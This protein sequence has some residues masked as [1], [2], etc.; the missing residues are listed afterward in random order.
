MMYSV[1]KT[2][3]FHGNSNF[4]V[5]LFILLL[6]TL[7]V[8]NFGK[9]YLIIFLS[10]SLLHVIIESGLTITGIRKGNTYLFEKK[11]HRVPEIMLRSFVEG[12][13]FC[14]PAFFVAD[15]Y[16]WGNILVPV[17]ASILIVGCASAYLAFS[18]RRNLRAFSSQDS[19]I[20]SRRA[21]TN[22]KAVMLLALVNTLCISIMLTIPME[23]RLH[24]S[25]Y[26]FSYAAFVLLFYF[27]NYNFGVRY[28]ELYNPV[29]GEY[30]KPNL[31][32][33]IAGLFYDSA[34]EMTILISPAYWIPLYMDF[35]Q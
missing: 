6:T 11:L 10:S 33:Q 30:N 28:I 17:L 5:L 12:P 9:N 14:V 22:P 31:G 13:A 23:H 19:V 15:Q 16:S 3:I 35:F 29:T 7:L 24:A 26:I 34:Y 2:T 8:V 20:I 4:Y 1:R 25:I 27:I 18:D 21:M 32:M